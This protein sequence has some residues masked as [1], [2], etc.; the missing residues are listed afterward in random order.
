MDLTAT[1]AELRALRGRA[2]WGLRQAADMAGLDPAELSR[3]ET[4][5]RFLSR[6]AAAKLERVLPGAMALHLR[7]QTVL[8]LD[9]SSAT[10]RGLPEV[11]ETLA[12]MARR[13][14]DFRCLEL[15]VGGIV[16]LPVTMV[17]GR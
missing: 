11:L 15:A 5:K 16:V 12:R 3:A 2:G 13:P 7:G 9:L 14:G 6:A 17:D 8:P 4:G 10:E 1:G